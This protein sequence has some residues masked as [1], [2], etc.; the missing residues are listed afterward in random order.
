MVE[1]NDHDL[2]NETKHAASNVESPSE[3][4]QV[5]WWLSLTPGDAVRMV[6]SQ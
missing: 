1:Q 2:K 4:H 5:T 6:T 3:G